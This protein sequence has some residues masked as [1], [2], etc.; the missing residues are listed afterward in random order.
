MMEN[1]EYKIEIL[2]KQYGLVRDFLHHYITFKELQKN[3][4]KFRGSI[5]WKLTSDAHLLQAILLWT[6]VFGSFNNEVHLNKLDSEDRAKNDFNTKL[7]IHL[8]LSE[9][10]W[11]AYRKSMIDFRNTFIAHRNPKFSNPVPILDVAYKCAIFYDE[12]IEEYVK[13]DFFTGL[14]IVEMIEDYKQEV[15]EILKDL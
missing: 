13:P 2:E 6:T 7:L 3:H 5:F 15:E 10:E 1:E 4:E 8:N 11:K 12:W 9:E 14:S